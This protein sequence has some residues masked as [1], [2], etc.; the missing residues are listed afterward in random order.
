VQNIG[1]GEI[2]LVLVIALLVF[3]PRRLPEIGRSLGKAWRVFQDESRR[4]T[5]VL[6]E[7][8]EERP[9]TP[10]APG[11]VD[12]PDHAPAAVTPPEPAPVAEARALEP[13]PEPV[14]PEVRQY[15]DT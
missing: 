9:D 3:G 7:G 11:V 2:F 1:F 14:P 10:T 13:E 4:A 12:R 8:L 5:E 15:E 6:R